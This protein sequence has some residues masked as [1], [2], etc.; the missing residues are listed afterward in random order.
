MIELSVIRD[1]IAIFGVI[2]GFSYYVLTVKNANLTRKQALARE[3]TQF[4]SDR[5]NVREFM[6]LLLME[7]DD[8][9]DYVRKFDSTVNIDNYTKR[10][11]LWNQFNRMGYEVYQGNIDIETVYN[12]LAYPSIRW[13]WNK[14]KPIILED[15]KRYGS[16][17][18]MKWM[19]YLIDEL[20]KERIR[21]GLPLEVNDSDGYYTN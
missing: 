16:P 21:Q 9:D 11:I 13:F 15:R 2:A 14:F 17:D 7:W 20:A 4:L 10:S 19:E 12:L 1:L 3:I 18:Y 5:D 6:E 8:F